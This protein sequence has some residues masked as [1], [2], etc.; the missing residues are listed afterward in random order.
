MDDIE[1]Y[2]KILGLNM[3]A[4]A[5]EVK[6]AYTDLVKVWHPDR[7]GHNPKLSAKA[8]EKMKEINEAYR[9]IKDFFENPSKYQHA[10]GS[11]QKD[12]GPKEFSQGS[13]KQSPDMDDMGVGATKISSSRAPVLPVIWFLLVVVVVFILFAIGAGIN[14]YYK[15]QRQEK[16]ASE[17]KAKKADQADF[18]KTM[19]GYKQELARR[20]LQQRKENYYACKNAASNNYHLNWKISC[21]RLGQMSDCLL[22]PSIGERWD[23]ILKE[24][25][26]RCYKEYQQNL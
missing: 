1:R 11:G 15:N 16:I 12:H 21:E 17:E 5:K 6:E 25:Q 3:G 18:E 8:Q 13:R 26:E 2:F 4:T 7:F 20:E 14:N 19:K 23:N 22:P 10:S 9:I 24:D